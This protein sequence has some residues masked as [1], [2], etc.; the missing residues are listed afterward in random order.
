MKR[1][2]R[3]EDT[4]HLTWM[5]WSG[6][7]KRRK[8]GLKWPKQYSDVFNLVTTVDLNNDVNFNK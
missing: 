3:R 5:K 2:E 6:K 7:E 1:T 4:S 8:S